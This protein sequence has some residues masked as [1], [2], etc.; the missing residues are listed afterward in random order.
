MFEYVVRDAGFRLN[1]RSYE[2]GDVVTGDDAEKIADDPHYQKKVI[3]RNAVVDAAPKAV[4]APKDP[5]SPD[6]RDRAALPG[7]VK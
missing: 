5:V 3:R 6:T 7:A 2:K 1:G 4:E